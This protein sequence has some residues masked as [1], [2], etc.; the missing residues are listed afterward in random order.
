MSKPRKVF[1]CTLCEGIYADDSVTQCDCMSP[2]NEFEQAHILPNDLRA[3]VLALCDLAEN[4]EQMHPT[5]W[6]VK[7]IGMAKRIKE[8]L[9][10]SE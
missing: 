4:H 8:R 10:G 3:D 6:A 2:A 5:T 7:F 1:I 9:R